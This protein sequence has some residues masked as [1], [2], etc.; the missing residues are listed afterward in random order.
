VVLHPHHDQGRQRE[1]AR[2]RGK[3]EQPPPATSQQPHGSPSLPDSGQDEADGPPAATAVV[4]GQPTEG[5]QEEGQKCG[6]DSGDDAQ[7]AGDEDKGGPASG[8]P[9]GGLRHALER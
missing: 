4:G 3:G 1:H 5:D 2:Q 7:D 9:D 6:D 8:C